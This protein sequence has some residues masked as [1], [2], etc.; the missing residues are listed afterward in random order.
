MR[1]PSYRR[2]QQG[3]RGAD[4]IV[5]RVQGEIV[6]RGEPIDEIEVAVQGD[7]TFSERPVIVRVTASARVLLAE[8]AIPSDQVDQIGTRRKGQ[9]ASGLPDPRL[10]TVG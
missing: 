8:E 2:H 5:R 4:V 6:L 9:T 7:E 1:R 10:R 3:T